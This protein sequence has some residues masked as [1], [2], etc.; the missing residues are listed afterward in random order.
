MLR[1]IALTCTHQSHHPPTNTQDA[2]DMAHPIQRFAGTPP[3]V[4]LQSKHLSSRKMLQTQ[5]STRVHAPPPS[6]CLH[7]AHLSLL[8]VSSS[9]ECRGSRQRMPGSRGRGLAR[10]PSTSRLPARCGDKCRF[11]TWCSAR[12]SVQGAWR[13]RA[14]CAVPWRQQGQRLGWGIDWLCDTKQGL[15]ARALGCALWAS[16]CAGGLLCLCH[17]RAQQL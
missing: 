4:G 9:P 10:D 14:A 6:V 1:L 12:A 17:V 11:I 13:A 15:P 16:D 8:P 7:G 2:T 5:P 3:R